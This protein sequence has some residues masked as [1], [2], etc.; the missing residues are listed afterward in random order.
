MRFFWLLASLIGTFGVTVSCSR[1]KRPGDGDVGAGPASAV[2]RTETASA[3]RPEPAAPA[4]P[5][6]AEQPSEADP[7]PAQEATSGAPLSWG[8]GE[9]QAVGPAGPASAWTRGVAL[10]DK[11]SQLLLLP[12]DRDEQIEMLPASPEGFAKYGRGPGIT[13]RFAYWI[14]LEGRLL[15][16]PLGDPG[17]VEPLHPSAR[18][19]TRVAALTR[20]DREVVAFV[21]MVDGEPTSMLWSSSGEVLQVSPEGSSAT[22]VALTPWGQGALV[23]THE[24]RTGMSPIHARPVRLAARRVS[25]GEDR[26]VWVGPGSHPLTEVQALSTGPEQILGFVTA[27]RSITEFGMARFAIGE[28][29]EP[30]D[31]TQ[32][33]LYPNGIDPAPVAA[34][35]LCGGHHVFFALPSS[36]HPRSPQELRVARIRGGAVEGAETLAQGRA[37]NDISVV[38]RPGGALLVW[39]ADRRTWAVTLRCPAAAEKP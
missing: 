18:P 10:V 6:P 30:V 33:M 9:L 24:G 19:G 38:S 2:G 37:F 7:S 1:D 11:Q 27:A 5:E 25:L 29:L 35:P 31:D 8:L 21:G 15:R 22:S 13:E 16:A 34:A 4:P 23:L 3:A 12:L 28:A 39:T 32:W 36:A 17:K 20:G 14:D 26:V